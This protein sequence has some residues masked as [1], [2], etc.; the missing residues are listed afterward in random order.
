M[1]NIKINKENILEHL[2]NKMFEIADVKET[3]ANLIGT[4]KDGWY[5]DNTWTKEQEKVFMDYAKPIL[6]KVLKL[7]EK[8]ANN[9][10]VWFLFDYGLKI[11]ND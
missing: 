6:K 1:S 2:I 5:S 11:E 10:L 9:E 7:N 3:Y 4:E 8:K